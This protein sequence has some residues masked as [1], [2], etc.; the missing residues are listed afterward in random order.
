MTEEN[1]PDEVGLSDEVTAVLRTLRLDDDGVRIADADF[2]AHRRTFEAIAPERR[3]ATC[4]ELLAAAIKVQREGGEGARP[5]L[6]QLTELCSILLVNR[7]VAE[8]LI[9]SVT[10]AEISKRPVGAEKVEG[11]VSPLGARFGDF[12]E[13]E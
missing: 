9:A 3:K 10:G 7:E 2:D 5:A 4:K 8:A 11:A 1:Q 13:K 12:G 6:E